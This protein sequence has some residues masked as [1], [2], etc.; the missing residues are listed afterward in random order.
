MT[1]STRARALTASFC[2]RR[3]VRCR[4]FE[5][6]RANFQL[7]RALYLQRSRAFCPCVSPPEDMV[8]AAVLR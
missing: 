6:S 7:Q 2:E 3:C 5:F 4:V 8:C 1:P